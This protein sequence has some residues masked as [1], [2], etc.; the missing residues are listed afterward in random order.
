MRVRDVGALALLLAATAGAVGCQSLFRQYE[1]EEELYV[2]LDGSATMVVNASIPA[3]VAL[4]G[5]TLDTGP[6][7]RP[8]REQL[9]ALYESSVCHVA[10][11][12]PPWYRHGRRY[13]QVRLDVN[14]IRRLAEARPF[15]WSTYQFAPDGEIYHYR[16]V[17][18]GSAAALGAGASTGVGPGAAAVPRDANWDGSEIVAVRLHLP[19]KIE[20]HNATSHE[21]ERG[22]IVSWEQP[23]RDRLSGQ[24]LEIDV[25]MQAQSILY[26]T[27]TIFGIALAAALA[28]MAGIVMWVRQKG[29]AAAA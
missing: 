13:F 23:L 14:D 18:G 1:Y 2:K 16:Q 4:R 25:C 17:L 5:L 19:S 27:L 6:N 24:P 10:R 9:R 15:N 7:A 8:E 22:N 3:L 11:V 12:S 26:R 21:V 20:Y 29:R 28:L